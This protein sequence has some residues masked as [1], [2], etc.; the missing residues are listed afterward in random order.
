MSNY[1]LAL[2]NYELF[3]LLRDS[4]SNQETKKATI[5][6]QLK[7]EYEKRAAA[8]SVKN[9]EEQ[10]VKDAQLQAQNAQIKNEKFQRY[11]LIVGLLF[12]VVG[13]LFVVNRFRITQKQKKII[14]EQKLKVDEA[15]EK[16][17]EKNKE[18]MDS[19]RYAKRIQTA[20]LTSEKYID[21]KIN[22][23]SKR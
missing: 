9:A 1:K 20:L 8:D 16:L 13:L 5:K 10:K 7:Y 6:N 21:R 14:E 15:F 2:E 12:V 3:I 11:A 22:S 4:I 19:I 18:V 23:L 17:A